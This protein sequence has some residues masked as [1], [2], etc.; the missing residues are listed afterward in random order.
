MNKPK[1]HLDRYPPVAHPVRGDGEDSQ[2][3]IGIDARRVT[4]DEATE[5]M[6]HHIALAVS[7]YEA[8]PADESA[9]RVEVERLFDDG[10]SG[11][12]GPEVTAARAFLTALNAYY[13]NLK[14]KFP[15]HDDEE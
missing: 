5:L 13:A 3:R 6:A 2:G 1:F 11:R 9:V 15:D 7:Y 8:T 12:T 10:V 4:R 14:K